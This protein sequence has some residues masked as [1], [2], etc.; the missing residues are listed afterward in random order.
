MKQLKILAAALGLAVSSG[1]LA[2]EIPLPPAGSLEDDNIE[3]VTDANGNIKTSGS[4]VPGDTLW[5]VVTFDKVMNPDNTTFFDIPSPG[6]SLELTGISALTVTSIGG[7]IAT[8]GPNATFEA[9]YG[10]GALAALFTDM[11]SDFSV[12]CASIATC[13]ASATDGSPWATFG[14]GDPDDFWVAGGTLGFP[15]TADLATIAATGAATKVA[16]ANYSLSVLSNST[17]YTFLDQDSPLSAMFAAGGGADLRTQI[18]GS[19]DVL[20]GA[21]LTN[22]FLARSDFDFTF[23]RAV[24]E[25][26][27]LALM[28]L[29]LVALGFRRRA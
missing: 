8:F 20:G 29:G 25:P 5:A 17:G 26:G 4:L 23:R 13:T 3:Y 10:T 28:G 1:A 9:T 7:G 19:G 21:G 11:P 18:V 15:I 2:A 27:V 16:V 22:G 14:L 6:G 12:G 24:P